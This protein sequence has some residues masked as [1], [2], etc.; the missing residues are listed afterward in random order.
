MAVM[1]P[2]TKP[3][4]AIL[5][6]AL[7]SQARHAACRCPS[8]VR[9]LTRAEQFRPKPATASPQLRARDHRAVRLPHRA[10]HLRSACERRPVPDPDDDDTWLGPRCVQLR[11]RAAELLWGVGQP[12]AGAVADRFGTLRVL[13]AGALLYAAGLV[14]MATSTTPSAMTIGAGVLIGFGLAGCSFNL[15]LGA[16]GKLLPE[17]WRPMAFGAGTAAGSFGQFLFPPVGNLMIETLGWQQAL[18][19][20]G[21]SVLAVLPLSL[22]LATRKAD[23]GAAASNA[24]SQPSRRR[25]R[26]LF[27]IVPMCCWCSVSSPAA[28]SSP[29]SP[30]ICRLI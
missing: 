3:C 17:K 6:A 29:S 4:W 9:S 24:P 10:H 23:E 5:R 22:A 13:C 20:F 27:R 7:W 18:M 21:V 8:L 15:V 11:H 26:R 1:Q 28:S 16:F 2:M 30:R 25:F 14:V 19:I 12:F